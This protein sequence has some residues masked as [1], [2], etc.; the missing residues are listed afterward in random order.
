MGAHVGKR[1]GTGTNDN[2]VVIE[3]TNISGLTNT[4]MLM[5]TAGAMDVLVSLDGTNWST[6]ALSLT[7]LGATTSDPVNVTAANRIYAFRGLFQGIRVLQN[8]ATAV[9]GAVL[10]YGSLD[11]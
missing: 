8:G 6:V 3:F 11:S 7:D 10:R 5:S 4:F 9:T 2:D 1:I